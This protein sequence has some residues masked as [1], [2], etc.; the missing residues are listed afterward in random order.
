MDWPRCRA[1]HPRH[2]CADAARATSAPAA[3]APLSRVP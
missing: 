2:E 3:G 1:H